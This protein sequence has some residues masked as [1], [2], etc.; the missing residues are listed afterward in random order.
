MDGL[1]NRIINVTQ[2]NYGK[3]QKVQLESDLSRGEHERW[4][5]DLTELEGYCW[6]NGK[7]YPKEEPKDF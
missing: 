2:I 1:Y 7:K 3:T 6:R 4:P 5:K